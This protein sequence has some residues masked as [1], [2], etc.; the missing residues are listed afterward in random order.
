M[1]HVMPQRMATSVK[2][3]IIYIT[4]M[5]HFVPQRILRK[6]TL[7]RSSE[8]WQHL[9]RSGGFAMHVGGEFPGLQME[10]WAI[11]E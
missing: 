1:M 7:V 3:R 2:L 8:H 9:L 11:R 10:F 6:F 4:R 5:M